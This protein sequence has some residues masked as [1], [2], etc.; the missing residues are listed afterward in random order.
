MR[1]TGSEGNIINT[2]S[3]AGIR[4]DSGMYGATKHAVNCINATLRSEL[5]D[6]PIRVTAIMPGVFATNFTRNVDR[7]LLEATAAMAGIEHPEFDADGRL[8]QDQVDRV[9]AAMAPMIGDVE[10][11]ADAVAHV[12]G[13]PVELNIEELVIRPQKSMF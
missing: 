9:Q 10:H 4:R 11:I 2:S 3:V 13:L 12:L 5:E 6:D 1:R 7:S 8:P